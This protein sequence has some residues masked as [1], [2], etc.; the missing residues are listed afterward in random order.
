MRGPFSPTKVNA[1]IAAGRS[2]LTRTVDRD[3]SRLHCHI[4]GYPDLA[5]FTHHEI[6]LCA[7]MRGANL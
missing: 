1:R 4:L 6:R 3:E 5:V 2:V 7:Q